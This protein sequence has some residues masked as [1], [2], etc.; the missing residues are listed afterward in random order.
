MQQVLGY[1]RVSTDKQTNE[2]QKHV[3]LEYAHNNNLRVNDIFTTT[4]SMI[5][6]RWR[7]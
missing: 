3:I 1:T 2:N 7:T 6:V 4:A 5:S